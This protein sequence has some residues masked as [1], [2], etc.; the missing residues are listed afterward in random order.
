MEFAQTKEI[1]NDL[2]FQYNGNGDTKPFE[3]VGT[4]EEVQYAIYLVSNQYF[5]KGEPLPYILNESFKAAQAG[6]YSELKFVDGRLVST[7]RWNP[8]HKWHVD[9][10]V[11]EKFRSL[12]Q[13]IIE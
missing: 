8:L 12:V 11:P 1:L 9:E 5:A 13:D 10:R 6:E 3:C 2:L 4:I 7:A